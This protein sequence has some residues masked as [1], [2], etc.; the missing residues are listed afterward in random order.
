MS[1]YIVKISLYSREHFGSLNVKLFHYRGARGGEEGSIL[2]PPSKPS[3]GTY[4]PHG[5]IS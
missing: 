2:M 3:G 5:T 4:T 1:T